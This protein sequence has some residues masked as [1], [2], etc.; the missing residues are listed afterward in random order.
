MN[1]LY[2]EYAK[3]MSD[4]GDKVNNI[5]SQFFG[6]KEDT[7]EELKHQYNTSLKAI[8]EY[9]EL[10]LAFMLTVVPDIVQN[11][12]EQVIE[13]IQMFIDG[14]KYMF[15]FINKS[16]SLVDIGYSLQHEGKERIVQLADQVCIKFGN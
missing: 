7:P 14:T 2:V 11:E 12:H 4:L 9:K 16:D 6:M 1:P 13:A 8:S 10:K 5:S 15:K 3:K